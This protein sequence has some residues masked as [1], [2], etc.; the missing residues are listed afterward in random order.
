MRK[1]GDA[2][3]TDGPVSEFMSSTGLLLMFGA[4][5]AF[6]MGIAAFGMGSVGFATL[7]MVA[8]LVSFSA[9]LLCFV[10]DGRRIEAAEAALPFPSM[11]R[12]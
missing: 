12:R 8:A 7:A 6:V 9:S 4:V 3:V 10:V 11:L 2:D 5:I 1:P